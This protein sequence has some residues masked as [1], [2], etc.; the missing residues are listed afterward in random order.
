MYLYLKYDFWSFFLF[1]LSSLNKKKKKQ[2]KQK[3]NHPKIQ[4]NF[5]LDFLL[6]D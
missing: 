3:N 6:S 2:P 5:E 1:F 4:N